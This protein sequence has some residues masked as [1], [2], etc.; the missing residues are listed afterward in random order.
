MTVAVSAIASRPDWRA[1]WAVLRPFLLALLAGLACFALLF[2]AEAVA[3]VRVWLDSTAYS[4]CFLVLPIALWL[5]WDR[6]EAA[7]GL[8]PEPTAWPALAVIPF[9]LAWFAAERLGLM[10]GRQ[11]AV[12]GMLEALLVALLGW[13]LARAQAPALIYLVFLVPVGSFLVPSLQHFTASFIDV[14][15]E[16][17]G[18]PHFV[19]AFS[20]E[21][22]EGMF[23]VAEA[24]AGL[25]FLIAAVAF[26]VLYGFLTYR[27]LGRR[28]GF[29]AASIVVPIIANG[30]RALGIVVAGHIVGDAEAAAADHIIYGWGFFSVVI[31]LLALAGLPFREDARP[32]APA[33]P[34]PA[35]GRPAGFGA[36][37]WVA[38][39]AALLAAAG[40]VAASALNRPHPVPAVHLPGF[41]ATADCLTLGDPPTGA[42]GRGEVVLEQHFSCGG[43]PLVASLRLL[44]PHAPPAMLRTARSE[45]TGERDAA[46]AVTST[47]EVD[48]PGLDAHVPHG[49]RLVEL[50][51]PARISATALWID[52]APAPGGL[53]GRLKLAWQSV[54]G[55]DAPAVLVAASLSPPPV[56]HA[57]QREQAQHLLRD[58]L[59][60][61]G[62]LLK[63]VA[64]ATRR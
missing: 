56:L 12:L 45:A 15:L 39:L 33:A 47:L 31:I 49:W 35:A 57:E 52:G 6:R 23:Y 9:G 19:D 18:I 10:E 26:G 13:R 60:A 5:A 24:C 46:D 16:A 20:V 44:P 55:T 25:R 48:G 30:F 58:F 43:S 61:Q 54:A 32:T 41:A 36:A 51:E 22:P 14:G 28:L 4:H 27:S 62:P 50:Q 11:L 64:E 59:A 7:R 3:A 34:P 2:H 38:G 8:Q 40:P 53:M 42:A 21:I 37:I 17:L 63:V 1:T 29:L